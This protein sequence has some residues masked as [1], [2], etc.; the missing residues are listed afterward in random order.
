MTKSKE[1]EKNKRAILCWLGLHK[2]SLWSSVSWDWAHPYQL[3]T[4]SACKK[5]EKE[6]CG[7]QIMKHTKEEKKGWER[8]CKKCN[9]EYRTVHGFSMC[10]SC[11]VEEMT[12]HNK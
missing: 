4:C 8:T 3:R 9:K 6:E 1:V 12:K 11:Y 2:W 10:P 5:V 7:R